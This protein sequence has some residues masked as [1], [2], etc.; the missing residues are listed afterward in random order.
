MRRDHR[1]SPLE[2]HGV[3]RSATEDLIPDGG[4]LVR[5]P[6]TY[7]GVHS[8]TDLHGRPVRAWFDLGPNP[9]TNLAVGLSIVLGF[10]ASAIP[11]VVV[12]R[13]R[14][15]TSVSDPVPVID[16]SQ[17]WVRFLIRDEEGRSLS[18]GGEARVSLWIAGAGIGTRPVGE[19]WTFRL[20]PTCFRTASV[21]YTRPDGTS[22]RKA[23]IVAQVGPLDLAPVVRRLSRPAGPLTVGIG[24]CA[25]PER[26]RPMEAGVKW[27]KL[28]EEQQ[29]TL[30]IR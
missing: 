11:K 7:R 30:G 18:V 12:E 2:S 6:S 15:P 23:E 5:R 21:V 4:P 22:Q 17:L 9:W 14:V 10:A 27:F 26:G 13:N 24:V 3:R 8:P 29:S 16:R 25:F 19:T 1:P 28:T 20:D